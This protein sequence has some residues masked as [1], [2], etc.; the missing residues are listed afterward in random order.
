[1]MHVLSGLG[2]D[3]EYVV[4]NLDHRLM[5]DPPVLSIDSLRDELSSKYEKLKHKY[6]KKLRPTPAFSMHPPDT[7]QEEMNAL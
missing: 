2:D 7:P 3:Y 5:A 6:A 1:M 4:Y